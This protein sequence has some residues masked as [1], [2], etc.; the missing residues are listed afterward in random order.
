VIIKENQEE[1]LNYL[2]D[3][4][5]F[6]SG[7][8]EALYIPENEDEAR[9]VLVE[10]SREKIPLTISG[11]GTGNVGS[12]IP[13]GGRVLSV[14]KLDT[15][16]RID[17]P[18]R[19]AILQA[20]VIVDRFLDLLEKEHLFY[21]PF[22]TER[23]AFISGNVSTN[24]S[25]EYSYRFGPTRKYIRR[26]KVILSDG[27]TIDLRRGEIFA[28]P[29]GFLQIGS[30][31]V[32]IPSYVTPDIKCSA[33]YFSR[34]RMDAIDLFIGSEGT[35]GLFTE[36]EVSL[37]PALPSAMIMVFFFS[38]GEKL[39]EF[40]KRVKEEER[41]SQTLTLEYFDPHSLNFLRQDFPGIPECRF[42]LYIEAPAD[43]TEDW[44]FLSEG[45]P[46]IDTWVGE[47]PSS[48]Q[49][50][51]NFRHHLPEKINDYFKKIGSQKVS[52]DFAV[53][54]ERFPELYS[55][56]EHIRSV[57][58]DL[59]TVLFG[60]IGESHLH[61]NFFPKN[62]EE[63]ER[64]DNLCEEAARKVLSLGG[65]IAAEHGIGKLKHKYLKMM[66]GE[67]GIIQMVTV[68]KALDPA[69]I[70]GLDNIFSRKYLV[71]S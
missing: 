27:E 40:L 70:L 55:Y 66:Y 42:A 23:S 9:K 22:P 68:K 35:L 16:I 43:T 11:G 56:Y 48:Y 49:R 10:C 60:H 50:L 69:G 58:R 59:E 67:E 31:K 38:E 46:I 33:G 24:A 5:N 32:K 14:E 28:D 3:S 57:N 53:P 52:L 17:V 65:T 19:R 7:C 45:Y 39:F 71:M 61:F 25:G 34:P 12:R 26:I 47:N 15:I 29:S 30:K 41:F 18:K 1:I 64:V 8:A 6:R 13:V 36:V 44:L 4:S 62:E 21:P 63:K 51:V 54:E 2:E 37:I 20:G